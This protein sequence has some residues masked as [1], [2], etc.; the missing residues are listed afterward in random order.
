MSRLKY[1]QQITM[2][3][4]HALLHLY[5]NIA[6]SKGC[7]PV[8]KRNALLV[9]WLKSNVKR[10][11]YDFVKKDIKA[12]IIIGRNSTGN[13]EDRLWALNKINNEY[14]SKFTEADQLY[15]L[16]THLYEQCGYASQLT[17]SCEDYEE[18]VIYMDPSEIETGFDEN[19]NQIRPLQMFISVEK[20]DPLI[21]EIDRHGGYIA[22]QVR[23]DG[24]HGYIEL[25]K[26]V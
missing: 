15:I 11:I 13:V 22:K 10:P 25:R 8:H 24:R 5:M 16:L 20:V 7:T 23:V 21:K 2:L 18:G 14:Q 9:K 26:T 19:S 3:V 1:H 17:G 12:L 4:N 6:A